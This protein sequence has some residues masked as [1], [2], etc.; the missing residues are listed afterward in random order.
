MH[1]A[2]V[3]RYSILFLAIVFC[4]TGVASAVTVNYQ[5]EFSARAGYGDTTFTA[6]TDKYVTTVGEWVPLHSALWVY[7]REW[8]EMCYCA[9]EDGHL[10]LILGPRG[11]TAP[12]WTR[13]IQAK[14][15]SKAPD[16]DVSW[17]PEPVDMDNTQTSLHFYD[18]NTPP[19]LVKAYGTG[20]ALIVTEGPPTLVRMSSM[21][22]EPIGRAAQVDWA[23]ASEV[24]TAGFQIL[25]SEEGGIF[26]LVSVPLIAAQGG[27]AMPA[28]YTWT[29]FGVTPGRAYEY[30]IVEVE[31][32][33]NKNEFGPIGIVIPERQR[34]R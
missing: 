9:G 16:D 11:T 4:W 23:T 3:L 1:S 33:G 28:R 26:E 6:V 10:S 14:F 31:D 21:R 18:M 8:T 12:G 17:S 27:P 2:K 24:G 13:S 30:K 22:V 20:G 7:G 32:S 34:R 15:N 25:R 19:N 29:D 5:F